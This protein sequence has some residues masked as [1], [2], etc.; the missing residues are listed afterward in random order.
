MGKRL[1]GALIGIA[2]ILGMR[3]YAKAS[4]HDDVKAKLVQL[5]ESDAECLADVRKHYDGC[6][7]ASYKGERVRP[8]RLDVDALVRCVNTRSGVPYFFVSSPPSP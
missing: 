1:A 5:C 7:E 2:A 6:F 8:S 4:A 3:F